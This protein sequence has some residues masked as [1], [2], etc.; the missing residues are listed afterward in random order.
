MFT[1]VMTSEE[2]SRRGLLLKPGR[3]IM[4]EPV[5]AKKTDGGLKSYDSLVNALYIRKSTGKNMLLNP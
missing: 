1:T 5:L 4:V 3:E 2:L